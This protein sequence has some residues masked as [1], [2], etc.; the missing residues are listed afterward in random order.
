M[1]NQYRPAVQHL[2]LP[3]SVPLMGGGIKRPTAARVAVALGNASISMVFVFNLDPRIDNLAINE[4]LQKASYA[5]PSTEELSSTQPGVSIHQHP[6]IQFRRIP[7][8]TFGIA[9]FRAAAPAAR[10][11]RALSGVQIFGKELFA[12]MEKRTFQ[13]LEQWKFLRGKELGAKVAS[14][15]Y[16]VPSNM[17]E[18][19]N[20]ELNE[21]VNKAKGFVVECAGS[22]ELRITRFQGLDPIQTLSKE[23][24]DRI[25]DVLVRKAE[26]AGKIDKANAELRALISQLREQER[27]LESIDREA[28]KHESESK[29]KRKFESKTKSI[30]GHP[31]LFELRQLVPRDR[32]QLFGSP[33]DW[34]SIFNPHRGGGSKSPV[35]RTLTPWIVRKVKDFLGAYD[36]ELVEYV[37]RRVRLRTDPLELTTDLRQYIDD[38][39]DEFVQ[40]IWSILVL[41]TVRRQHC[42]SAHVDMTHFVRQ[43]L[44]DKPPSFDQ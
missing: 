1:L 7:N 4:M 20:N 38:D 13:L 22:H 11:A 14:Q 30:T 32:D 44:S 29:T 40:Q 41:E 18:L 9:L 15:G 8:E 43:I 31:S 34:E 25:Q 37:L 35:I 6:F 5:P 42:S 21:Q 27:S 2:Q 28:E 24:E 12:Q 23:E 26:E 10:A 33:I 19:V 16:E 36:R 3:S 39:A 17:M